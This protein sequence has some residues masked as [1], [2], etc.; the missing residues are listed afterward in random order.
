MHHNNYINKHSGYVSEIQ[1]HW[2]V[3][4]SL[5]AH[6]LILVQTIISKVCHVNSYTDCLLPF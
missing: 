2:G 5:Y 4:T 3:L 1:V 6:H